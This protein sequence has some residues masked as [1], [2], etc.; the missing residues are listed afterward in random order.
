VSQRD[1]RPIL[2]VTV[3]QGA[4][5]MEERFVWNSNDFVHLRN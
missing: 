5:R 2:T 3:S 1:H 4:R